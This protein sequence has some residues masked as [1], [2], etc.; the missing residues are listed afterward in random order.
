MPRTPPRA[1]WP[2]LL[3]LKVAAAPSIL[4]KSQHAT[5]GLFLRHLPAAPSLIT[6]DAPSPPPCAAR[7]PSGAA[8]VPYSLARSALE[9]V[10]GAGNPGQE[11]ERVHECPVC[12]KATGSSH[13]CSESTN[14]NI[15]VDGHDDED[16]GGAH[17]DSNIDASN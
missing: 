15:D 16:L 13:V 7:A 2:L 5:R 8:P 17:I 1:P 9:I 10:A 3:L 14:N 11:V 4:K 12:T 6:A